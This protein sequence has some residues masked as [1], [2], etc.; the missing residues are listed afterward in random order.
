MNINS[1]NTPSPLYHLWLIILT[2][3]SLTRSPP[4]PR[5]RYHNPPAKIYLARFAR[6]KP[7]CDCATRGCIKNP[8]R[9]NG[10]T[11]EYHRGGF[12]PLG[13]DRT[14]YHREGGKQNRI[15]L[16]VHSFLSVPYRLWGVV[17]S[18]GEVRWE[19]LH[20]RISICS[21]VADVVVVDIDVD[22]V[23]NVVYPTLLRLSPSHL[24]STSRAEPLTVSQ[25]P[26]AQAVGQ[27]LLLITIRPVTPWVPFWTP[28]LWCACLPACLPACRECHPSVSREAERR[29][30]RIGVGNGLIWDHSHWDIQMWM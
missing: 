18:V 4:H 9:F 22:G 3:P 27:P 17:V 24:L 5:A 2:V 20:L 1:V 21:S 29:V 30:V 19:V 28:G 8:K 16:T 7:V 23:V 14:G 12:T 11:A 13:V 10:V 26:T 6:L 25:V 15:R